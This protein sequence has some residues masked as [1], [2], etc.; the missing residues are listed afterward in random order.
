M[1]HSRASHDSSKLREILKL[2]E[3]ALVFVCV[4]PPP[5]GEQGPGVALCDP[6]MAAPTPPTGAV[7]GGVGSGIAAQLPA[8]ALCGVGASLAGANAGVLA[9]GAG[10]APATPCWG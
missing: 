10:G 3:S 8:C 6:H 2:G 1:I 4:P 9:G 7:C 5:L